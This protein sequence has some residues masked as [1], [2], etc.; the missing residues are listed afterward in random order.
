[1]SKTF[2]YWRGFQG[3]P[4][5]ILLLCDL[6]P[7]PDRLYSASSTGQTRKLANP[8]LRRA[9]RLKLLVIGWGFYCLFWLMFVF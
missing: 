9:V 5:C 6:F 8:A 3:I 7:M 4:F 2:Q 1:M